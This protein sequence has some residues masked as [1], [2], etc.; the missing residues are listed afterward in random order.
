MLRK[1]AIFIILIFWPLNLFLNNTFTN[2]FHYVFP[3]FE[4]KFAILP[5]IFVIFYFGFKKPKLL[6]V[7]IVFLLLFFKAFFGQTVFRFDYEANQQIL[8]KQNLYPTIFM[9]RVFQNKLRIPFDKISNNFFALTDPNNYFFGYAPRQITVSNQNLKKFPFLALP[10]LILGIYHFKNIRYKKVVLVFLIAAI[11]N[12]SLLTNFDRN[13]FVLWLPL[14]L[15]VIHGTNYLKNKLYYF[16]FLVFAIPELI[17]IF[18][19]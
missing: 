10:F 8:Q 12:L 6:L 2:F 3:L 18:I 1:I 13:D 11:F 17:R 5:L 9:A 14:A 16:V 15:V 7:S 19:S 4:P